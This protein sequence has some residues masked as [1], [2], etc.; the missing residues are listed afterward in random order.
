VAVQHDGRGNPHQLL[1]NEANLPALAQL[2]RALV[3]THEEHFG[4]SDDLLIGLQLTHSGRFA[5]P[6][7]RDRLEPRILYHHPLL[8]RKFGIPAKQP[9]AA[10][11]VLAA[12]DAG[13]DARLPLSSGGLAGGA[14]S[15]GVEIVPSYGIV[16]PPQDDLGLCFGEPG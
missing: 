16:H 9:L 14:A 7:R 13:S 3:E 6:N 10:G 4:R 11:Q 8:D 15:T 2:R 12:A 1:I 5:R